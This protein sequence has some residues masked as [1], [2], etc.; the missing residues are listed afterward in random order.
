M[1][2]SSRSVNHQN[3]TGH[4]LWHLAQLVLWQSVTFEICYC[5]LSLKHGKRHRNTVFSGE[6]EHQGLST[7]GYLVL[8][9]N[10]GITK[11]PGPKSKWQIRRWKSTP[12]LMQGKQVLTYRQP[13]SD[14]KAAF[15]DQIR[16]QVMHLDR[17]ALSQSLLVPE[18][19]ETRT[20]LVYV[21]PLVSQWVYALRATIFS[22]RMPK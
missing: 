21:Q 4:H 3:F 22:W 10:K 1:A 13:L 18:K 14:G 20:V 15:T 19:K 5:C 7:H 16:R 8:A 6:C 17:K 9:H 2:F 12:W 11:L